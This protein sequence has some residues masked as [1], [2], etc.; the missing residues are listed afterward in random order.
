MIYHRVFMFFFSPAAL[1]GICVSACTT[2]IGGAILII[3]ILAM[4]AK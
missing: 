1:D 3:K 2:A 4:Q